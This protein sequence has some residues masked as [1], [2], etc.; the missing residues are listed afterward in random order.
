M[1]RQHSALAE[2]RLADDESVASDIVHHQVHR[3]R[4][5]HA[6]RSEE[7]EQRV[8]RQW[9]Q[10]GFG[11]EMSGGVQKLKQFFRRENVG[12]WPLAFGAE[13]HVLGHDFMR[14]IL[15]SRMNGETAHHSEAAFPLVRR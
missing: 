1:Q 9:P 7:Y 13:E 5:A 10:G 11:S 4:D 15:G 6:R 3:L 2:L 8:V 12:E 14:R